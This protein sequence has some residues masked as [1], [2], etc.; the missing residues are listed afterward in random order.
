MIW[1]IKQLTKESN[2]IVKSLFSCSYR[3]L[4]VYTT[5][6]MHVFDAFLIMIKWSIFMF[7]Y[8]GKHHNFAIF[9]CRHAE[10]SMNI[11]LNWTTLF[12]KLKTAL[13]IKVIVSNSKD[14]FKWN[15]NLELKDSIITIASE[16][17][18]QVFFYYYFIMC[19]VKCK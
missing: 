15:H 1:C 6:V 9:V 3:V 12:E 2:L 7:R 18:E 10:N 17:E 13:C 4:Y 5:A 14:F 11:R 16:S 8:K 19:A